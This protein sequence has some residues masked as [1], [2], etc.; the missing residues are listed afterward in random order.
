MLGMIAYQLRLK[1]RVYIQIIFLKIIY[2]KRN[3]AL[4][5]T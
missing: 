3:I 5:L 1:I 4:T 2:R